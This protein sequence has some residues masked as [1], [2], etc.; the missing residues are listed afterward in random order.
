MKNLDLHSPTFKAILEDFGRDLDLWNYNE[1]TVYYMP[2]HLQEFFHY[3]ETKG[4]QTLEYITTKR[5]SEYYE[6]LSNRK[7]QRRSGALSNAALN[8]HQ[9]ALK[10]FLKYLKKKK[11]VLT[12]GVHL[13]SEKSTSITLKDILSVEEVMELFA[14]C[15]YSHSSKHIRLRDKA[16][17]T[18]MYSCGL[19]THQ[20]VGLDLKDVD[21]DKGRLMIRSGSQKK[22][23]NQ[24][25]Q[26]LLPN[27]MKIL[28]DFMNLSRPLFYHAEYCDSLFVNKNGGRMLG[29]SHRNRL[30]AIIRATENEDL[31]EKK[32]APHNL[33]HSIATHLL[34]NGMPFQKVSEFLGHTSL[35]STQIYT[36]LVEQINAG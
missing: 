25:Y 18:L 33:R 1:K 31:M 19:R 21:F 8:K 22:K 6:Y 2:I 12:F 32:I 29:K 34:L 16:I 9:Q 26:V 30:Q 7:N 28:D 14:A 10:L 36:H 17:L 23:R 35:E 27:Q 20:V 4:Y 13:K 3:L 24:P 5:V 11:Q 15:D